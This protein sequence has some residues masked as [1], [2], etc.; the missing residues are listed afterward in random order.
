MKV[1]VIAANTARVRQA[2]EGRARGVEGSA[3]RIVRRSKR[4]SREE[5]VNPQKTA[6][7]RSFVF[8]A[9][10]GGLIHRARIDR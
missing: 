3:R 2:V 9:S 4:G 5:I 8:K 1:N 7:E 10:C 6:H